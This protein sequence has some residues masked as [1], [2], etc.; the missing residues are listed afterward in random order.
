[1][2]INILLPFKEKFD[3][4][5]ASSVSITIKNNLNHSHY[6]DDIQVFG[7]KTENPLFKKNFWGFNYSFLSLKR[8][9]CF[10]ADQMLKVI[11]NC[12]DKYQIIEIHNR[13]YLLDRVIKKTC[14][15]PITLFFHNDPKTMRGSKSILEREKIIEQCAA[16]FCVSKY[17]RKQFLDGI[18]VNHNKVYV[19]HNG[20]DRTIN[21]LPIKKKEV[22]FVGRL[23]FEKGVDLYVDSVSAVAK[24]FPD[25]N[26]GLIGSYRL[27]DNDNTNSY[28]DKLIKKF[29]KIGN[30]A[31]FYG[32]KDHDFVQEKMKDAS[33]IIIPSLWNEPFGLVAAE[34]MSNGIAIIASKVGGIPEIIQKNG[35]L[36]E[37]IN[38]KKLENTLIDLIK[39]GKKR[40]TYQNKAWN[41][42]KLSSK[43][44][45]DKLDEYRRFIFQSYYKFCANLDIEKQQSQLQTK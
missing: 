32:F 23:V 39:N 18:K 10:L 35:I 9:N 45:S 2:K 12:D 38:Q 6:I 43:C 26:F 31:K 25:W 3:E 27:G 15:F 30:K 17:I 42:F 34:A 29:K 36:I 4:K 21:K 16:I 24:M 22:L 37:N 14:K 40:N 1:M 44:S 7:Q 33:V 28:A 5:K 11:L 41:N 20:V 8:K 19:L 13:P